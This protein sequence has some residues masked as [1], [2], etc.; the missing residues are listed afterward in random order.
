[1]CSSTTHNAAAPTC[2]LA[3]WMGAAMA[4]ERARFRAALEKKDE[5]I[6]E[7]VRQMTHDHSLVV[8]MLEAKAA[9]ATAK[10]A[11]EVRGLQLDTL[12]LSHDG[13]AWQQKCRK[14][15]HDHIDAHVEHHNESVKLHQTLKQAD[16]V[17]R[18]LRKKHLALRRET[19]RQE[20]V[21]KLELECA[22]SR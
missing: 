4:T 15:Q 1:M 2:R 20:S 10:Y 8:Q 22:R 11:A 5:Q 16:S 7:V 6:A 9:A 14:L 19:A 13:Y 17:Q 3:K 12:A 21:L 18:E